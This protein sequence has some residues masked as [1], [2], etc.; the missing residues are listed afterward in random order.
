MAYSGSGV[1]KHSTA[2]RVVV[3]GCHVYIIISLWQLGCEFAVGTGSSRGDQSIG[4]RMTHHH[5]GIRHTRSRLVIV[6]KLVTYLHLK[7]SV[8]SRNGLHTERD[9]KSIGILCIQ[10]DVSSDG[11][12]ELHIVSGSHAK[13]DS[14]RFTI[15]QRSH[16]ERCDGCEPGLALWKNQ[17]HLACRTAANI[18]HSEC[19]VARFTLD[20]RCLDVGLVGFEHSDGR[21]VVVSDVHIEGCSLIAAHFHLQDMPFQVGLRC[22]SLNGVREAAQVATLDERNAVEGYLHVVGTILDLCTYVGK[23][24][25]TGII[26]HQ[27]VFLGITQ[28]ELVRYSACTLASQTQDVEGCHL[29]VKSL[30]RVTSAHREVSQLHGCGSIGGGVG[31]ILVGHRIEHLTT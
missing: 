11:Y 10:G 22:Q 27:T 4:C 5:F 19:E 17:A 1:N 15:G 24:N 9:G 2:I 23:G 12:I 8:L 3:V 6:G 13:N 20:H 16:I 18:A 7:S 21:E 30:A 14:G 26:E 29:A 25:G 31:S 28:R